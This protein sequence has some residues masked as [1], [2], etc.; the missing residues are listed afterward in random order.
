MNG[1]IFIG[2]AIGVFLIIRNKRRGNKNDFS[3]DMPKELEKHRSQI[4]YAGEETV[5]DLKELGYIKPGCESKLKTRLTKNFKGIKSEWANELLT[6]EAVDEAPD[7]YDIDAI[8]QR[9]Y[10]RFGNFQQLK[11]WKKDGVI[12]VKVQPQNGNR[13]TCENAAKH[14]GVYKIDKAPILPCE[15]CDSDNCL[16]WYS[17]DRWKD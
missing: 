16:C 1:M 14:A 15:D 8:W 3:L 12:S 4:K 13:S 11:A 10:K 17:I 2:L 9:H 5:K 6:D 7:G